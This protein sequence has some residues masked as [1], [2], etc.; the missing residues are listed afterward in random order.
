[1]NKFFIFAIALTLTSASAFA[2]P[3]YQCTAKKENILLMAKGE[4]AFFLSSSMYAPGV[5]VAMNPG[6]KAIDKFAA[7]YTGTIPCSD[8]L[9]NVCR[10][11]VLVRLDLDGDMVARNRNGKVLLDGTT[12]QCHMLDQG[13]SRIGAAASSSAGSADVEVCGQITYAKDGTRMFLQNLKDGTQ[14]NPAS[15][16]AS[17]SFSQKKQ[18]QI[19]QLLDQY[20]TYHEVCV[21]TDSNHSNGSDIVVEKI[22][23][24]RLE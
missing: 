11:V 12:Y 23:L 3:S 13:N 8:N 4:N 14:D 7:V 17:K 10:H 5:D 1:M 6:D 24:H 19:N 20:A 2:A 18:G 16:Y 15:L 22:T 21:I 9:E